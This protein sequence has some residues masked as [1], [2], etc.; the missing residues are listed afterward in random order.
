MT[1]ASLSDSSIVTI[2]ATD[3]E[4]L[5]IEALRA[6]QIRLTRPRRVIVA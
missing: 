3:W 5:V 1:G 6:D 2:S 4:R